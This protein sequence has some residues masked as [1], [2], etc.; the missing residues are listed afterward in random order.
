MDTFGS[1]LRQIR[2]PEKLEEFSARFGVAPGTMGNYERDRNQPP[3]ELVSKICSHFGIFPEWLL[4]GTGP[5]YRDESRDQ[6]AQLEIL[7]IEAIPGED[8]IYVPLVAARLSAGMGSLEVSDAVERRYAFPSS[9]LHRKGNPAKMVVMRVEGQSMQPEIMDGD[10]VLID[11]SKTNIR[12]GRIFALSIEEAI[13]LKRID[14]LPGKAILKSVN[15]DYPP[16]EIELT[17]QLAD[18]MRVI[19]QVLWV[20]RE[21]QE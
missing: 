7:P 6:E 9:F 18:Q 17:G 16:V 14:L 11:Q 4:F 19:G 5:K 21:Y 12:L 10:V 15:P 1:R 2:K 3:F 8:M 20:G 13:Y